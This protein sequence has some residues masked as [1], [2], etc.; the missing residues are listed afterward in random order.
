[1]SQLYQKVVSFE[2]LYQA[3][4]KTRLNKRGRKSVAHYERFM[5]MVHIC[6][7]CHLVEIQMASVNEYR[8]NK[9]IAPLSYSIIR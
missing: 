7:F 3:F 5:E 6:Q 2:N 8:T 4:L 9:R 1:M